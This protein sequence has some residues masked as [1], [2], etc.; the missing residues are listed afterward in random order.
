MK[1]SRIATVRPKCSSFQTSA[2]LIPRPA[3][4]QLW[5]VQPSVG[6]PDANRKLTKSR[7]TIKHP[8]NGRT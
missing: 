2:A 8:K 4:D 5:F 7:Q 3:A 1:H 6:V